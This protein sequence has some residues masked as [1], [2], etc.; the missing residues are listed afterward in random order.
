MTKRMQ[1]LRERGFQYV[2]FDNIEK[3]GESDADQIDYTQKLG[4]VA[5]ATGLGPLF[6]NVAD[7]IRKDKTVQDNFVG[8]ICEESIQW[9]D[10]EV[11]HEVAAGK[12]P[13]WIF[14]YEDVSS[15]D[16]SKNK[17]L[18]TEIWFDTNSGWKS[19]A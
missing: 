6:K 19:L 12:K 18:A 17:S 15:S 7:L 9:G 11:F 2:E 13:I 16:V 5:V 10:T 8:F 14:E 4:E 1:K 3:S